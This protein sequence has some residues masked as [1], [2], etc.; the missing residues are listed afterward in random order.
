MLPSKWGTAHPE[1][2]SVLLLQGAIPVNRGNANEN[3]CVKGRNGRTNHDVLPNP[4]LSPTALRSGPGV[5][6][7]PTQGLDCAGFRRMV[8]LTAFCLDFFS[9]IDSLER[10]AGARPG[11]CLDEGVQSW[12]SP[13]RCTD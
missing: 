4:P 2:L 12:R 8:I 6:L 9:P 11:R 1:S 10:I 5:S 13:G 7:L 3:V